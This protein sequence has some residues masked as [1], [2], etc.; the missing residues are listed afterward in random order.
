LARRDTAEAL[1]RLLAL[2][3]SAFAN[4][5]RVRLLK[6]QLLAATGRERDALKVFDP[7]VRLPRSPL[8]VLG[9]LER[10]HAAERRGERAKAIECYQFVVDVWRH[11]DPEL[12]DHVS[13]AREA[14]ARL[15]PG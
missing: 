3:D 10:G 8:W 2:P 5:W 15:A 6:F 9:M 13:E 11:A 1:R 14:L 7:R 4:D 12:Q